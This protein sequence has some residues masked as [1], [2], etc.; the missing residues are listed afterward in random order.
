MV[1]EMV[2]QEEPKQEVALRRRDFFD[3]F[4]DDWPELLRHP[5]FF[6]PERALGPV[7]VEEFSEGGTLVVRAELPG[8]DPDK[9][10]DV[11]VEGDMLH[12]SAERREDEETKGRDYVR[13]E[14]RYGSYR[15]DIQLPKGTSDTDITASY[16]DGILEVRVPV[17]RV[18]T[19]AGKKIPIAKA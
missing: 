9:D 18:E 15:R 13:R 16:N 6:W 10:L 3:R 1:M 4:F 12:I 17:A 5:V 8:I 19:Q 14:H 2:R 11:S 7:R